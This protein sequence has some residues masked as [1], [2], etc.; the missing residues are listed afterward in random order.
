MTK[1]LPLLSIA[2]LGAA[3]AAQAH[4]I[5]L[6]QPSGQGAVIRFGEFG[7]NLRE[8]SPGLLD[9]FGK[10][11]ATLLSAKGNSNADGSKTATGFAL[12]FAAGQGDSIVA[13]DAQYPLYTSKLGEKETRN[14]YY[15][16]AR[17]ITSFAAQDARLTLDVVPTGAPGEFKVV[18][19]GQALPKAKV[20]LVVQSG[21]AREARSDAQGLVKFDMP[22]KGTYVAEI[23]HNDRTAGE[24]PGGTGAE[25]YD[26]VSYVTTLTYVKSDGIEPLPAGPAAVTP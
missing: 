23:I 20:N 8:A 9:K 2:L 22:W 18:F 13:H 1:L 19:K 4:Q 11:V 25:K 10:P 6:E 24:R 15:P 3:G 17:L 26:G 5:W 16:A 12:P 21:W 14:W 7:D